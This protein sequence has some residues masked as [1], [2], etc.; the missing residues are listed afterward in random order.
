[1]GINRPPVGFNEYDVIYFAE[2]NGNIW[3]SKK[4]N[5][6]EKEP[7]K[8][9]SDFFDTEGEIYSVGAADQKIFE[10]LNRRKGRR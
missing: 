10:K 1:M 5:A 8:Y 6:I 4:F 3:V 2:L 9:V 7:G